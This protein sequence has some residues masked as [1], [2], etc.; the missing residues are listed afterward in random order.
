M[1]KKNK[2]NKSKEGNRVKHRQEASEGK[3]RRSTLVGRYVQA[4]L[5]GSVLDNGK[6]IVS[7]PYVL[8]LMFLALLYIANNYYAQQKIREMNNLEK[9]IKELR[10]EYRTINSNLMFES[11]QSEVARK[12]K[13]T[14]I[15]ES[16]E[17]PKKIFANPKND[18]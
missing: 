8:F 18:Q 4:V 15:K 17:P 6:K 5:D 11:K 9:D 10:F 2:K 16:T 3:K 13:G 12:L 7:L 1:I 14:G